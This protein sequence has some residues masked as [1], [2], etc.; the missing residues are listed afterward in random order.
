MKALLA[1]PLFFIASISHSQII[2]NNDINK[3]TGT[4]R[5]TVGVD[6]VEIVLEKQ[7]A[8]LPLTGTSSETLVGWHRYVR[9]GVI[10]Q[11]SMQHVGRDINVDFNSTASDL[12]TTLRGT[13][14]DTRPNEVFFYTCWDLVT[15][16]SVNLYFELLPS[17]TTQATWKLKGNSV[18]PRN[19]VL[20]KL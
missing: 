16:K 20:T 17:S 4:W 8:T 15:H 5:W 7:V 14:Y 13:A 3:F 11:S 6:T 18:L 12:K 19:L 10:N 9:N 2:T 1:L